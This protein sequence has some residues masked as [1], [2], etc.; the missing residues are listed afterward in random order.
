MRSA[1]TTCRRLLKPLDRSASRLTPLLEK[2]LIALAPT[3][4]CDETGHSPSRRRGGCNRRRRC[5][6]ET[7]RRPA[8]GRVIEV[9]L[10]RSRG[11]SL[12]QKLASGAYDFDE[13]IAGV[14][15]AMNGPEGA[16]LDPLA[17]RS[18]QVCPDRRVPGYRRASVGRLRAG[19]CRERGRPPRLSDRRPQAGDLRV[20]RGRRPRLPRGP[21]IA[22]RAARPA[23][24]P[25]GGTTTARPPS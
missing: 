24:D 11:F 6:P 9:C 3:T 22:R 1:R 13:I 19:V 18:L 14:V 16:E 4:S 12:Q 2:K 7:A 5:A 23:G 15:R 17:P 10:P 21:R 20:S 8:Q 25:A